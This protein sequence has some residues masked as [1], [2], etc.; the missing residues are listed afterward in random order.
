MPEL[1]AR[2]HAVG[3]ALPLTRGDERGWDCWRPCFQDVGGQRI[4]DG[5]AASDVF[6]TAL[7]PFA[8]GDATSFSTTCA[9]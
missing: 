5:W 1:A 9:T 3:A 4:A 8:R 2:L 7:E 6:V